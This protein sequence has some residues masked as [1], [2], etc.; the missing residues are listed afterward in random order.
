MR[1][2]SNNYLGAEQ[3]FFKKTGLKIIKGHLSV[4]KINKKVSIIIPVYNNPDS[5]RKVLVAL[6]EQKIPA[7]VH[8][9]IEVAI[10][11]NETICSLVAPTYNKNLS[12]NFIKSNPDFRKV[13]GESKRVP[14][15]WHKT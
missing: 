3:Y 9:N 2:H 13:I 7:G 1:I 11:L 14:I 10:S 6:Q 12:K 5:L 8:K 4:Q 15:S